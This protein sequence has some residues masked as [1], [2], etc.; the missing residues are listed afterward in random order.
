MDEYEAKR[1]K[2]FMKP[3]CPVKIGDKIYKNYHV[4]NSLIKYQVTDIRECEDEEGVYYAI[5]AVAE[6]IAVGNNTKTFSSRYI[7]KSD[8]YTIEKR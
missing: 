7:S 3:S 2:E 8:E 5:T 6:N 1:I 4:P